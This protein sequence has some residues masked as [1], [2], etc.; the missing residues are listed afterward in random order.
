MF[1]SEVPKSCAWVLSRHVCLCQVVELGKKLP[2]TREKISDL[3][4]KLYS[5]CPPAA[6]VSEEMLVT[7]V[8]LAWHMLSPGK[9]SQYLSKISW[10]GAGEGAGAASPACPHLSGHLGGE[11]NP[12]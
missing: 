11:G 4:L 7:Q 6:L 5:L 8:W 12:S 1:S 9:S 10:H 2:E 3:S